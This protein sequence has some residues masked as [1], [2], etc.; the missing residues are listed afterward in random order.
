MTSADVNSSFFFFFFFKASSEFACPAKPFSSLIEPRDIYIYKKRLEASSCQE[1]S[2]PVWPSQLP[3]SA[4]SSAP[5]NTV[6]SGKHRSSQQ[7]DDKRL[8]SKNKYG[9]GWFPGTCISLEHVS[10]N[11]LR[12]HETT[13]VCTQ[14]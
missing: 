4:Q 10:I 14:P 6:N 2:R 11:A 9:F 12:L 5:V 3:R 7:K 1:K 13:L 8:I